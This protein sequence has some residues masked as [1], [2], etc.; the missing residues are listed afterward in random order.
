[1]DD[2]FVDLGMQAEEV[3]AN[4]E[5]GDMVTMDRSLEVVGDCLMSKSLDNRLSVYIM[6]E[7]SR[8]AENSKAKIIAVATTQ[9]EVGLRGAGVAAFH[10]D[11]DI[12][13]ALDSTLAVD[14]PESKA[15]SRVTTM[16][17]GV[18]LKVM[19]SSVISHPK[20]LRHFRD[21]AEAEGIPYQ[22]EI[23]PRGGTDAGATQRVRG[24]NVAI[25]ISVPT[26]YV[27]TVNEMAS[28]SD[29][30]GCV[31]LLTAYLNDVG[32]RTYEL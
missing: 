19:D 11:P 25:T 18:A 13:I 7:A 5:I 8:A 24:G 30:R 28:V 4:V 6:L 26:R 14:I 27:H 21:L 32:S 1:M 3:R 10:I 16:R 31:S 22:L 9:E 20:L 12:S 2:L 29:V 17:E 15:F 23:L